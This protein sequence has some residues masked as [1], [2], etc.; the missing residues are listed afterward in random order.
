MI[1]RGTQA[2]DIFDV[3]QREEVGKPDARHGKGT[4]PRAGCEHQHAVIEV[5]PVPQQD[6]ALPH[7]H[8]CGCG[9]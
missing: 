9:P 8:F 5:A 2:A 1:E 3:S 7:V 6:P 4:R